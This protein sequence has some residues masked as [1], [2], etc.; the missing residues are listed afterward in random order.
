M[1]SPKTTIAA[2][3]FGFAMLSTPPSQAASYTMAAY[4]GDWD[5]VAETW[6]RK[7]TNDDPGNGSGCAASPDMW[8][9]KV[10]SALGVGTVIHGNHD[11]FSLGPPFSGSVSRTRYVTVCKN[12]NYITYRLRISLSGCGMWICDTVWGATVMRSRGVAHEEKH[13]GN[14][15]NIFEVLLNPK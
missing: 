9:K 15:S 11:I 14:L 8:T 5:T 6:H 13:T 2:L 7:T 4:D 3:A 12:G 10:S 1:K